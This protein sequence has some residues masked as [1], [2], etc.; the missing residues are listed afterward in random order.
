[1]SYAKLKAWWQLASI[2]W[3]CLILGWVVVIASWLLSW[4]FPS[5]G[6]VL[7]CCVVVAEIL[8]KEWEFFEDTEKSMSEESSLHLSR[9]HRRRLGKLSKAGEKRWETAKRVYKWIHW[10]MAVNVIIGTVIWGYGHRII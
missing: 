10:A 8:F 5:S 7:I 1:M 9:Y 4:E 3:V 6:A 2:V